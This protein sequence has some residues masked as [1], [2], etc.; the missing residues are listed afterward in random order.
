MM[1]RAILFM[2]I[3]LFFTAC[4]EN[5]KIRPSSKV[6]KVGV[7]APQSGV[8]EKLGMQS[9]LGLNAAKKM[10]KYLKN[11]DEIIFEIMDTASDINSTKNAFSKLLKKDIK[12]FISFMNTTDTKAM[13]DEFKNHKVPIISTLATDNNIT[14][15]DGYLTQVCIDNNTQVLVASHY[16]LD[17][18]FI[19]NVGIIYDKTSLYSTSLANGFNKYHT[20]L[21]G[22]IEFILD[23]SSKD[24]ITKFKEQDKS[25]IKMLFNATSTKISTKVLKMMHDENYK[26]QMLATDGLFSSALML[27]KDELKLFDG[28][29]VIGHYAH[30]VNKTNKR[31]HLE[32]LLDKDGLKDS[33]Y[34]FLAYDGY[35]LLVYALENCSG[36]NTKCINSIMQNSDVINGLSGNFTMIDS[37]AR[38]EVYVDKIQDS[39]LIKEVVIY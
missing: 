20:E 33:S 15:L 24:S 38:R 17:E 28:V 31:L 13:S 3:I 1:Q 9:L 5:Q 35:Q 29:Y 21:G 10:N 11:G 27:K 8:S 18:K 22:K 34:A 14:S 26:F 2:S 25:K 30:N 7:L 32:K 19:E 36:Y 37:K 16:I 4:G 6:I 39:Q 23:M 12:I